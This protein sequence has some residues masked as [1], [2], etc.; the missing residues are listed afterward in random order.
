M[1]PETQTHTGRMPCDDKGG[2]EWSDMSTSQGMPKIAGSNRKLEK[3]GVEQILPQR[4]Q[5]E[6]T[7]PTP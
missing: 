1:D 7:L 4:L 6:P 2:R 3:R 5:L